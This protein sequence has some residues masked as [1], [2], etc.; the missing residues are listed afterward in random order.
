MRKIIPHPM[1]SASLTLVWM[2]LTEFSLGHLLLGLMIALSAG[3]ALALIHPA[4]RRIKRWDL[5]IKLFFVIGG[6]IIKSNAEVFWMIVTKGHRGARHSGFVAVDLKLRDH[7]GLMVMA[8]AVTATPGS[9][10]IK[11]DPETGR[12]LVHVFDLNDEDIWRR[13]LQDRYERV[14]MEIYE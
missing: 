8:L 10:W 3:R 13:T 5:L 9:A 4:A 2:A 14:L 1:V 12:L 11:H 6:D 7:F